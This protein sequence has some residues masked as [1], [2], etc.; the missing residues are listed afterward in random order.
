MNWTEVLTIIISILVPMMAGFGWI[1]SK[2]SDLDRR[3]T[4]VE[5]ILTMMGAPIK[6]KK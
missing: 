1:I 3:M 5:T 6:E 4:I 2:L